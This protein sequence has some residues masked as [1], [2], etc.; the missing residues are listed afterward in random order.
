MEL[1]HRRSR[2][3]RV[4]TLYAC[5]VH[6]GTI[7]RFLFRLLVQS[8]FRTHCSQLFN[9]SARGVCVWLQHSWRPEG[10]SDV[11][12]STSFAKASERCRTVAQ[13]VRSE[14]WCP[15]LTSSCRPVVFSRMGPV[16]SVA[17]RTLCLQ[18][19]ARVVSH[20]HRTSVAM[21]GDFVGQV[22][23]SDAGDR[24]VSRRSTARRVQAPGV[25]VW[26]LSWPSGRG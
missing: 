10:L 20:R 4:A 19:E 5:C 25:P 15:C 22:E 11:A 21:A 6:P 3:C 1:R 2:N 16:Q 7:S 24:A 18:T 17:R 23:S 26:H 8:S 12:A 14:P 13:S 9:C